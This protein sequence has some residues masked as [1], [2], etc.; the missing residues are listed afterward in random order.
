MLFLWALCDSTSC[1]SSN[2]PE[3]RPGLFWLH[4]DFS[5]LSQ[6]KRHCSPTLLLVLMPWLFVDYSL[7]PYPGFS[8]WFP[9]LISPASCLNFK[10]RLWWVGLQTGS[11]RWVSVS[12]QANIMLQW[13]A[14]RNFFSLRLRGQRNPQN[15]QQTYNTSL[16]T[17]LWH[18]KYTE[19]E[20]SSGKLWEP[21]K[22]AWFPA[23]TSIPYRGVSKKVLLWKCVLYI[24]QWK[25]NK[26]P[27][28]RL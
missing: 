4:H 7:T 28:D 8:D 14:Q 19:I 12:Y 11:I 15:S 3:L 2:L 13:F 5:N 18:Y 9:V 26:M 25:G 21:I 20:F 10:I 6:Q 23:R 27:D 17:K 16:I 1:I 24:L 22:R